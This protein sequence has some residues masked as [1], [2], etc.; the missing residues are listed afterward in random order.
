MGL[1]IPAGPHG[2]FLRFRFRV[3]TRFVARLSMGSVARTTGLQFEDDD[4]ERAWLRVEENDG[5]AGVDAVSVQ[6]FR[7]A[8][9]ENL[10]GIQRA[11]R[12][13][14]YRFLP[15]LQILVE[16]KPGSVATRRLLVPVVRDRV[17]LTA[18]ARR[19]S[20]SFEDEFLDA[21]Y[22]YR[23]GRSV[24]RAV[25]RVI[26]LRDR[27]M[28]YV[29]D[30]DIHSFF[31]SVPHPKLMEI[32]AAREL[33]APMFALLRDAIH[34]SYWDG[35]RLRR[36]GR[37]VPQGSPLSPLLAN[38][39]LTGFDAELAACDGHLVRYADD[40]LV[41][42]RTEA[43]ANAAKALAMDWMERH[44]LALKPEKTRITSFA[45]SF[46][47]LGVTFQG[48]QAFV[49][50]KYQRTAG[51]VVQMAPPMPPPL[52]EHW[53]R[54]RRTAMEEAL[55]RA[56]VVAVKSKDPAGEGAGRSGT[57]GRRGKAVA[58]LY[59][60]EQGSVLRKSGD[61]FLVELEDRIVL[62]LPYHQLESVAV[63]GAV[64]VTTQ[65]MGELLEKG[66]P[67]SYFTRQGRLRGSLNPPYGLDVPLRVA[68]FELYKDPQRA[69][70]FARRTVAAKI[71]N[72]QRV[73]A[74]YGSRAKMLREVEGG[75][76]RLAGYASAAEKAETLDAAM[77]YEG[78]AAKEYFELLMRFNRSG[79]AWPGRKKF[80]STDPLNALLSFSYTLLMHELSGLLEAL[81]VDPFLGFLHQPDYGRR[82]LALDL[83]EPFRHPVADRL[84]L[85]LCN[86]RVFGE[87]DFRREDEREGLVLRDEAL[88]RF[89]AEYERWMR[90]EPSDGDGKPLRLSFRN[91]LKR[92]AEGFVGMLKKGRA[93]EPYR[94]NESLSEAEAAWI[95]S[96]VTT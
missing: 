84:V 61:R 5:C 69:L 73:V 52:L 60:T 76:A 3:W 10:R 65:A 54:P 9:W 86:R 19:L 14:Q 23:P 90:A 32:L 63:F 70:D 7:T 2:G 41:L 88:K 29:L 81:G 24:D 83:L 21:S 59:L 57:P 11:V 36:L 77:G 64:Q 91:A 95:P 51:K 40:F 67:L 80:P 31:D 17:L 50:W 43:A 96:S 49:P 93:W 13:Q 78:S 89:L 16:K 22:A 38:L 48:E 68:Q 92:E 74:Q 4:L 58:H 72:G 18:M 6:R 42:C 37:G 34:A 47:F 45:E 26:Q 62:D 56:R 46:A 39:F 53:R 15:L 85:A 71:A 30:A 33:A 44:G 94:W 35:R 20:H 27:G 1:Q 12:E 79:F 28:H 87:E 66:I 82:S 25:A 8:L 75:L 55:H